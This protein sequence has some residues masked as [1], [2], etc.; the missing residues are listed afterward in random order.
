MTLA[1]KNAKTV[2]IDE[3]K[4]HIAGIAKKSGGIEWSFGRKRGLEI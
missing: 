1:S 2:V 3:K 4:L